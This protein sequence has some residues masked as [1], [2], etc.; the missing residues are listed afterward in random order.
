[1]KQLTC[2]MCGGTDLIKDGGVFVCQTC[3]CKYSIEEAK[4]M[5]I[6]GTVE[7]A[8]TVKID[9][10]DNYK[11]LVQLARDAITDG[12]FDGAYNYCSEALMITPNDP[13]MIA[14]QGLAVLGKE[15]IVTDVPSSSV[16]AMK[17][18]S[19]VLPDYKA[20]FD[21]KREMLYSLKKAV[22]GVIKFKKVLYDEQISNLNSQK[23]AY[24]VSEET[25]AAANLALQALGGN[26]FTQQK[27]EADLEKAT[28]KRLHNEGLEAQ[29]SKICDKI[30]KME[31]FAD[32]FKK[33][34]DAC[35]Q[36]VS[37]EETEFKEGRKAAYWEAHKAEKE[38]L[39]AKLAALKEELRP[40][41]EKI[42]QKRNEIN[43]IEKELRSA[44]VPAYRKR[45]QLID[46]VCDLERRRANLGLFKGK[47]KKQITEEIAKINAQMPTEADIQREKVELKK[48]KQPQLDELRSEIAGW[49]KQ[50]ADLNAKISEVN[51]ELTK[52][53]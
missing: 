48:T 5:M 10:S 8:G 7:V 21:E 42:S 18:M 30:Q 46:E 50:A 38:E 44:D 34:V 19:S 28:A 9:R 31:N 51:D 25:G 14:M 2:E 27:A 32:R 20:S 12:R 3:G 35:L 43:V 40:I 29:I 33:E 13:E 26:I 11:N 23:V 41:T 15:E 47:E 39:D 36:K 17:R 22:D 16:N 6:E 45:E 49:E 52:E 37:K 4:R 24:K 1:M 53:R